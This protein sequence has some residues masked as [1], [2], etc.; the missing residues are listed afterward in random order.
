LKSK[1]T[2]KNQEDN[3]WLWIILLTV[4]MMHLIL[5]LVF[6]ACFQRAQRAS[7]VLYREVSRIATDASDAA[8]ASGVNSRDVEEEL[9]IFVSCFKIKQLQHQ[10]LSIQ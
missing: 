9:R 1:K 8:G 4:K 5:E 7:S 10:A 2:K 6:Y 3:N